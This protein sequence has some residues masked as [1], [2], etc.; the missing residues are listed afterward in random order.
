MD[1]RSASAGRRGVARHG[2]SAPRRAAHAALAGLVM[3]LVVACSSSPNASPGRSAPAVTDAT[4]GV[5]GTPSSTASRPAATSS[6]W[7]TY[8][9]TNDRAGLGVGIRPP[10]S[11]RAGWTTKVDGAVYGQ[12]LVVGDSVIA[13]TE[14]DSVYALSLA[15]GAVRWRA[16]LGTPVPQA[17]LPC[18]NIDPVGI[19]GTPAYDGATGS[20]FVVTETT[21]SAHDLVA[22][23]AATGAVRFRRNLDVGGHDRVAQQQ[24]AAL[25]VANGR[26]YVAF[27]GRFGDCGDYIG[28][29][30]ASATDGAG[31][32]AR[33]AV[34]TAK[35][36]G[37]WAP[38]GAAIGSDGSV[39]VAVGNGAST[40]GAYDGSDAVVRLRPDLSGRLDF[41][42][43]RA[44]ASQNASDLDLGSTGPALL[45][46]G[47]VV[48]AGKAGTV[49]LLDA[50]KL[51]GIGGE[52]ATASGCT[53]F[54][55]MAADGAAV[56]IPC[57]EGLR[58]FNTAGRRLT[59]RWQ[60]PATGS[61]TVGGGAVWSLVTDAGVLHAYD[62][63]TGADRARID[64]GAV[65]RFA[66]PVLTPTRVLVGT[67]AAVVAV[68]I[69]G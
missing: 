63:A 4:T 39:Y 9:R 28:Y 60:A 20:V 12:A 24:R 21:G 58:R 31:S 69:V 30:T 29:L 44:W 36:G 41:F 26:V 27:G 46:G 17:D 5:T 45:A 51:G 64:V 25:A 13:A 18:G 61:P 8:H 48:S 35:E 37:I 57:S 14:N 47:L 11:L 32:V 1:E 56:F 7:P 59:A 68:D 33:Y 53:G 54:G 19:T 38:P 16:H 49:Y 55:G 2:P 66:S 52:L 34:P 65:T 15:N 23:D 6:L 42:A 3:G 62:E 40:R 22:L 10:G 43:P 67:K 50:N